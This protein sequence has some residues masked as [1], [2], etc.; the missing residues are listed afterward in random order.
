M[1]TKNLTEAEKLE[2][3]AAKLESKVESDK[4]AIAEFAQKVLEA[5]GYA[6]TWADSVFGASARVLT[7]NLI[8]KAIRSRADHENLPPM[9]IAEVREYVTEQVVSKAQYPS[10]STS[11]CTNLMKECELAAWATI[12]DI[13]KWE[14]L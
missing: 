8:I 2:A 14:G 10:R 13:M 9:T 7:Y 6:L 12:L 5:P 1:Q 11:A 3:L 4:K